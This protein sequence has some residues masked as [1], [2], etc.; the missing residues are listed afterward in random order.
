MNI[1]P[2]KELAKKIINSLLTKNMLKFSNRQ[3]LEHQIVFGQMNREEWRLL[4]E[5][6][7]LKMKESKNG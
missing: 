1:E 5:N 4:A 7:L 2:D 3:K 6:E